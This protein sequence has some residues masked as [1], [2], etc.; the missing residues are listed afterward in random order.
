MT[1]IF[2]W[3]VWSAWFAQKAGATPQEWGAAWNEAMVDDSPDGPL[4]PNVAD[5]KPC[6]EAL[7]GEHDQE[8]C[9]QCNQYGEN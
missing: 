5:G 6:L 7:F 3:L 9:V 8:A 1:D 4:R 2:D